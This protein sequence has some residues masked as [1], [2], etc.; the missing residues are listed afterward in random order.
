M[1]GGL[2]P[3]LYADAIFQHI[4]H[5]TIITRYD[6]FGTQQEMEFLHMLSFR[7]SGIRQL[8]E[9]M[10][11]HL[12]NLF[13][14]LKTPRQFKLYNDGQLAY[15]VGVFLIFIFNCYTCLNGSPFNL[16]FN[17]EP[18]LLQKYLLLHENLQHYILHDDVEY[19]FLYFRL[20]Y[21]YL[22][23]IYLF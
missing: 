18:P 15:H 8:I 12:F 6:L 20:V 1:A 5:T 11:E 13:R 21:I 7:M 14:L 10:Y 4:N 17:T 19:N 22:Y 3:L 16:M 9:H 2:L 23:N